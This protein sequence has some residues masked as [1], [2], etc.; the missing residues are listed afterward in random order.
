MSDLFVPE[1]GKNPLKTRQDLAQALL[2]ICRPLKG[3]YSPGGSM[4]HV[5]DT[6][7]HYGEKAA[8]MEGFA[9]VLWGLGPLFAG[10]VSGLPGEMGRETKEWLE[11]YRRGLIGGTDPTG[12]EYWGD[13]G[14]YDQKMVEM[15]P[16]ALAL[17][18]A[19]EGLW[20]PLTD[21]QKENVFLWL[22]QINAR[23][24]HPNNWRFFRI[25]VNM[26]FRLKGLPYSGENLESDFGVVE[27]CYAGDGWYFDGDPDQMDYYIPFAMHFYGLIYAKLMKALE[28]ER[29]SRLEARAAR[30]AK[31]FI[32][33]FAKDGTEIPYGRSLTYR[34]AHGAFFSALAFDGCEVLPWGEIKSAV[35]G[36]LRSWFSRPIFDARGIL[37]IGYGY[38]NLI[39]SERYN[40]PGSPYW[41]LKTFLL[42]ALGEDHPFWKA[43]EKPAELPAKTLQSRNRMLVTR[44]GSGEHV[45]AFVSGQHC[46]NHGNT[47]AKYEKFVYSN[48]FGFSVP[49]GNG[50][51]DGAFDCTLAVSAAGEDFYRMR[52][53]V[54]RYEVTVDY[55]CSS[56][57]ILPGVHADSYVVP[58]MPWHVRIHIIENASAIDIADGAFAV[59]IQPPFTAVPGRGSGK[60]EERDVIRRD[61]ALFACFPWGTSGIVSSCGGEFTLVRAF[62]NTNLFSSVTVIPTFRARLGPGRHV[63]VTAVLGD[64]SER[65]RDFADH[66]PAV[67]KTETGFR[68]AYGGR[69]VT[70]RLKEKKNVF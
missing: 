24:V 21:R 29:C 50:L 53:G 4:L 22:N 31:D 39:M 18:I 67:E 42:L 1:I 25:L 10:S 36:N 26:M 35:L 49:R 45:M 56:C 65:A 61:G 59:G 34:F 54:E 33:W 12:G 70:I 66:P 52:C 15:A 19:S 17:C 43:G 5:G 11:F 63:I 38:P 32:A 14:D 60:Y 6:G 48:R 27:S 2:C 40:A 58:F 16:V 13:V 23:R 68:A 30:F 7:A 46:Q 69:T 8:R 64:V 62:P 3:L 9:R 47:P 44:D 28:P 41:A 51:E 37:T 55:T 20:D 57:E